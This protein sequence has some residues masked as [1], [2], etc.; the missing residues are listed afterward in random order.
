[1]TAA[2]CVH[3]GCSEPAVAILA[4]DYRESTAWLDDIGSAPDGSHLPLCITHAD[5]LRVPM[6]WRLEDRRTAV[7]GVRAKFA[8]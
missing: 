2:H 3:P 5:R 4:Y 7:I 6:G 8:G 1:M